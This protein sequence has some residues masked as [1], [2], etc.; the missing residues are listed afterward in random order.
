MGSSQSS[1]TADPKSFQPET[2]IQFSEDL[3]SRLTDQIASHGIPVA[4][5]SSLDHHIRSRITSELERLRAEEDEVRS[6]IEHALRQENL[7]RDALSNIPDKTSQSLTENSSVILQEEIDSV[8]QQVARFPRRAPEEYQFS[9]KTE[10][11][12]LCYKKHSAK[13]LNCWL[14]VDSFK[15]AVAK[16]EHEYIKSVQE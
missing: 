8:Q 9:K 4:R 13:P 15:T 11:L 16:I 10:D 12:I 7:D 1:I 14:M 6:A 5:Q 2:T 3:V